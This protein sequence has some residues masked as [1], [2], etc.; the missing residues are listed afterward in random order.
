MDI[1]KLTVNNQNGRIEVQ[2][3]SIAMWC[4]CCLFGCIN[5][6]APPPEIEW[7]T[8]DIMPN[9][10]GFIENENESTPIKGS[11]YWYANP[12][13]T[14]DTIYVTVEKDG[15]ES[16][17]TWY[18]ADEERNDGS[19]FRSWDVKNICISGQLSKGGYEE[20][21]YVG[22]GFDLCTTEAEEEPY[23]F[24]HTVGTCPYHGREKLLKTFLG[25]A[26]DVRFQTQFPDSSR[27]TV[28]FK[29]RGKNLDAIQPYCYIRDETG[30]DSEKGHNA[31]E[32]AHLDTEQ[33]AYAVTAWHGDA[34]HPDRVKDTDSGIAERNLWA[35]QGIHFQIESVATDDTAFHFCLDSIRAISSVRDLDRKV[36]GPPDL[37]EISAGKASVGDTRCLSQLP[38]D[39]ADRT[40][41]DSLE[42][43]ARDNV[44]IDARLPS[45]DCPREP[46]P[47]DRPFWIMKKEVSAAQF[48]EWANN[49]EHNADIR[50]WDSCT[51]N[52]YQLAIDRE[53][54]DEIVRWGKT[55]ANCINWEDANAFCKWLGGKLPTKE[56][57][58]YAAASGCS[59]QNESYPWGGAQ[60]PNCDN[61]NFYDNH[62]PGCGNNGIPEAGC[63]RPAGNTRTGVCDI[64]GNL[65]EWVANKYEKKY[66]WMTN[67]HVIKGGGYNTPHITESDY[68]FDSLSIGSS[69]SAEHRTEPHNPNRL[70][71]RCIIED[72]SHMCEDD[73]GEKKK[74][75]D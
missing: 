75:P 27:F 66:D 53:Q 20:E 11:W 56:Q 33:L 58:E 41:S 6:P 68:D 62:G 44:W 32:F 69:T 72:Q 3:V 8:T 15:K 18:S 40:L 60:A 16:V 5:V 4:V 55:S 23:Q 70:G 25:I 19:A 22:I 7:D 71:F 39:I 26:F 24:P 73:D 29:E 37:G 34:S 52:R 1:L 61:A 59:D 35:L 50:P 36:G 28:Q 64:I 42:D 17:H 2:L 49:P 30:R 74:D 57:W 31:C 43:E 12:S 65:F 21:L 63:H 14:I 48:F 47:E 46:Y 13:T 51:V 45:D 54:H 10:N 38:G 9:W 67:Y